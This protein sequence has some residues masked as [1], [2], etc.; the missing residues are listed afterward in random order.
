MF[1]NLLDGLSKYFTEDAGEEDD[2]TA[3]TQD[4]I[5]EIFGKLTTAC[6]ELDMDAMEECSKELEEYSYG[7][8]KEI[9]DK[10]IEAIRNM[11]PDSI[12]EVMEEYR[13]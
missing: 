7:N 2:K 12:T 13:K 1:E 3:I 5:D 11:D 9:I 10:L 6:D 8:K 4:K